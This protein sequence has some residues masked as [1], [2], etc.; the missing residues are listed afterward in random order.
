MVK[1][2]IGIINA[3]LRITC[4]LTSLAWATSKMV[5]RPYCASYLWIAMIGAMKV[6][7][8]ITRYCPMVDLFNQMKQNCECTHEE[9]EPTINPS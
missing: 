8:G 3:L 4:G 7:E 9:D 2:N 1:Q 6:A 5:R